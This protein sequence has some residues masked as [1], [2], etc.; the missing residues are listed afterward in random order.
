MKFVSVAM[1]RHHGLILQCLSSTGWNGPMSNC[2]CKNIFPELVCNV[3]FFPS[4]VKGCI[5]N[6]VEYN[7]MG[8]TSIILS[9]ASEAGSPTNRL[10][11]GQRLDTGQGPFSPSS[12]YI[13]QILTDH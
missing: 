6:F 11:S 2:D 8:R 5:L 1:I 4:F 12:V 13:L 9:R 3:I 10:G 7:I